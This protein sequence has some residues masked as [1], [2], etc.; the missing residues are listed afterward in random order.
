MTDNSSSDIPW[1]MSDT[2]TFTDVTHDGK[3][4]TVPS[5][6]HPVDLPDPPPVDFDELNHTISNLDFSSVAALQEQTIA[7]AITATKLSVYRTATLTWLY[8]HQQQLAIDHARAVLDEPF[9]S[10]VDSAIVAD[11]ETDELNYQVKKI[12]ALIH[13]SDS[14]ERRQWETAHELLQLLRSLEYRHQDL[15]NPQP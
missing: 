8:E 15:R 12:R 9:L 5:A 11:I 10:G 3:R 7:A 4:V 6:P 2:D 13:R 14:V 1:E